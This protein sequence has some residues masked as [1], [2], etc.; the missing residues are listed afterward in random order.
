MSETYRARTFVPE[1]VQAA[2]ALAVEL[3][4]TLSCRPEVGRL[5][6]TL[7]ATVRDGRIGERGTGC[8]YGAASPI[9][10]APS[11]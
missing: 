1:L 10:R 5:L 3:G 7:A 2:E 8:G 11:G 4:F 6:H 9:R